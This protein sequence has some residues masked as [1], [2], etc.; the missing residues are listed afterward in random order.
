MK[1]NLSVLLPAIVVMLLML[2]PTGYAHGKH[3]ESAIIK[4]N[5]PL[6]Y[7]PFVSAEDSQANWDNHAET[8]IPKSPPPPCDTCK[9]KSGKESDASR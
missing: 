9:S 2:S 5:I 8:A 4:A 6:V 1:K 7:P 3:D